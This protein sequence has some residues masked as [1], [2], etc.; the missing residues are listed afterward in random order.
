[1]RPILV[2]GDDVRRE[3]KDNARHGRTGVN[4]LNADTLFCSLYI[5]VCLI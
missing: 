2:K 1:M 5:C 4:G 3:T